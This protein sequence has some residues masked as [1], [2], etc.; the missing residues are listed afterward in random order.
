MNAERF[1]SNAFS[2]KSYILL[3][4]DIRNRLCKYLHKPEACVDITTTALWQTPLN[5]Q[6][7]VFHFYI[8]YKESD[9]LHTCCIGNILNFNKPVQVS[10][11]LLPALQKST[12]HSLQIKHFLSRPEHV[13]LRRTSLRRCVITHAASRKC[14]HTNM[15]DEKWLK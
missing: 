9:H 2:S 15:E 10:S 6:K 3:R 13:A 7:H 12:H 8:F 14:S 1:I 4:W 11:F 5:L